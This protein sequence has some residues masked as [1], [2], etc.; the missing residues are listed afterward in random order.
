VKLLAS[1]PVGTNWVFFGASL[2]LDSFYWQLIGL[3]Q[4]YVSPFSY[5]WVAKVHEHLG[6][7][8]DTPFVF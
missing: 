7:V 6:R 5:I 1:D 2:S 8:L 4:S 3:L